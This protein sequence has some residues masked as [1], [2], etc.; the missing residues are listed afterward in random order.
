MANPGNPPTSP[1]ALPGELRPLVQQQL[2]AL[3][4][5]T[6]AWQGQVWPGQDMLWEIGSDLDGQRDAD[7]AEARHWQ[8]RLKLDLPSLGPIDAMLR[9]RPGQGIE[10]AIVTGQA[11]GERR[12]EAQMM[13]L[14]AHFAAAGLNL[15]Q[16][17]IRHVPPAE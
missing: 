14:Q 6:F 8:T 1:T 13:D 7:G 10:I 5:Q 15:N 2:D 4:T 11:A 16:L 17:N 3:A 9:L 12:L